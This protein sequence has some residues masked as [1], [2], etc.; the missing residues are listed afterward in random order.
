MRGEVPPRTCDLKHL[1]AKHVAY[2]ENIGII[3]GGASRNGSQPVRTASQD[4]RVNPSEKSNLW[5]ER[6][7]D[8]EK[9]RDVYL[10]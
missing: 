4:I 3:K 2:C 10:T 8:G 5:T 7:A 9:F 1:R 6:P